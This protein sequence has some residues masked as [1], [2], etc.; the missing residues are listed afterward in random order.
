M[1]P[2][3]IALL[4]A[5]IVP[6]R[7]VGVQ[8][9]RRGGNNRLYRLESSDGVRALKVYLRQPHDPRDRQGAEAQALEFFA[10]HGMSQVPRLLR[11]D[12]RQGWTIMEWIDGRPVDRYDGRDV[13][14]A[15][16][17]IEMSFLAGKKM[18]VGALPLA[19]DAVLSGEMLTRHIERRHQRLRPVLGDHPDLAHFIQDRLVPFIRE[20]TASANSHFQ[21]RGGDF[22]ETIV[23]MLRLPSPSDFGFHNALR[24]SDD[25]LVFLDFEYFGWDDPVKLASDMILHPG[26]DLAK[27][28]AD[29]QHDEKYH[30][31][32]VDGFT[33]IFHAD[34][35]F[36]FRLR[37]LFP[38][39]GVLWIFILLNEF[40]TDGWHRR[41]YAGQP[42]DRT[43]ACERQLTKARRLMQRLEHGMMAP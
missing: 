25:M 8:Q 27:L 7:Q 5:R 10:R 42:Q 31:Q 22:A 3:E 16:D 11:Q 26:M 41:A 39:F 40:L 15:L 18:E 23:P 28:Y 34:P 14:Q 32:I 19:A 12:R 1:E 43:E 29:G 17:F 24:R 4:V 2:D 6:G 36:S 21:R 38:L 9:V 20:K 13:Q 30:N 37:H 35:G 33:R